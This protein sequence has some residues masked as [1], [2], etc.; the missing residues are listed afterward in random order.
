VAVSQIIPL[1][2]LA[3]QYQLPKLHHILC[4]A[5][6]Q[7]SYTPSATYRLLKQALHSGSSELMEALQRK[8]ERLAGGQ[9]QAALLPECS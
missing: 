9:I 3:D 7:C 2:Q 6:S 5:V 1:L 4:R 8:L